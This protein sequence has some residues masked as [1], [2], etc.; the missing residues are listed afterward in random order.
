V[1]ELSWS[2]S[3]D[4]VG[5]EGYKVYLDNKEVASVTATSCRFTSIERGKVYTF[6]VRA[7]DAAKNLSEPSNSVTQRTLG[8]K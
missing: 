1:F 8:A 5:V 7:F 2:A 4:D 6:V 3:T